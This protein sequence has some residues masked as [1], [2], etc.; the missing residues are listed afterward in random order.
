MPHFGPEI[1]LVSVHLF[2]NR[3]ISACM[4]LGDFNRA[5]YAAFM[6]DDYLLLRLFLDA[7]RDALDQLVLRPAAGPRLRNRGMA[8]L[9]SFMPRAL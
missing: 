4:I 5:K 8:S 2:V 7:S 1:L 3:H 6:V 9:S